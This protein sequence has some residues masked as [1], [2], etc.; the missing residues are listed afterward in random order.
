MPFEELKARQAVARGSAASEEVAPAVADM[1][2]AL[3][4][5]V[6]ATPGERA[7]DVGTG[8]G[9][10]ACR[11]ARAGADVVGIDLAPALVEAAKSVADSLEP[12]RRD[13]LYRTRADFFEGFRADG[14]IRHSRT[15]LLVTGIRR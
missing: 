3:V 7:M 2:D 15:Y 13:E 9:A 5:A 12:D 8:T 6:D 4:D 1:H 11:L 10:V 14:E